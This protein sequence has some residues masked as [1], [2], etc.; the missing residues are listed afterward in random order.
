MADPKFGTELKRFRLRAGKTQS[1]LADAMGVGF[2][3]VSKIEQHKAPPPKRDR[4]ERAAR[5]L[6]LSENEEISLLLLAE[7]VPADVQ[8]LVLDQEKAAQLYRKIQK[9]P[10][11]QHEAILDD[12]IRRVDRRLKKLG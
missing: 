3:Y 6:E 7:K 8:E 2:T 11:N 10:A 9:A 12:L 4:I 1:E 5:F